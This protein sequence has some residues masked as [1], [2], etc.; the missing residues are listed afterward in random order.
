MRSSFVWNVW[1]NIPA[2]GQ[3]TKDMDIDFA[4]ILPYEI[5]V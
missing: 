5:K 1:I 3:I 4:T 2:S